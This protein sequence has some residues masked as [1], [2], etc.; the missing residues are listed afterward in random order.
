M[1]SDRHR[2][3]D[4]VQETLLA[5]LQTRD[6]F[7]EEASERTWLTAILRHKIIDQRRRDEIRQRFNEAD[8]AVEGNF[9][10]LGKWRVPP[11]KWAS[12]PHRALESQEFWTI[13][14]SCLQAV[15]EAAREP[16]V[17]R[18]LQNHS[19]GEVCNILGISDSN[20]WTLLFRAR[21]RLRRCLEFKWF[22]R[23]DG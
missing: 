12:D 19:A 8:P 13:F 2:A 15:P 6:F 23:K 22:S 7:T 16:F 14:D 18:V 11:R 3:E 10:A 20:L 9:G 4:L 17:L 5:A 21:E 1:T